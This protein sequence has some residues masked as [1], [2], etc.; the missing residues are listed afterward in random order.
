MIEVY[1]PDYQV[2]SISS[3][4]ESVVTG[5]HFIMNLP[6]VLSVK[7]QFMFLRISPILVGFIVLHYCSRTQCYLRSEP[8]SRAALIGEQPNPWDLIY[9][10]PYC[11]GYQTIPSPF[12]QLSPAGN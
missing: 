7:K 12:S 8:S 9:V 11:Y 1:I 4:K 2:P 6:S 5:I 3:I 10:F